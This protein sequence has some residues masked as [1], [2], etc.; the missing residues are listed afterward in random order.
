M[1]VDDLA[2]PHVAGLSDGAYLVDILNAEVYAAGAEGLGQ[3]VV[4]V[5]L[6][7]REVVQPVL[8]H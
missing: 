8:D 7:I 4:G 3:A 1:L 6:M 5:V 2:F